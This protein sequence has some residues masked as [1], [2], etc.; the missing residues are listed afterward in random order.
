V[1]LWRQIGARAIA[2]VI[3]KVSATGGGLALVGID[4]WLALGC[5]AWV[6]ALEFAEELAKQ[7]LKDGEITEAELNASAKRL[8]TKNEKSK[9]QK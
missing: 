1:K 5:A 2:W 8:I 3:L 9:V 6:G 4:T 7:Y